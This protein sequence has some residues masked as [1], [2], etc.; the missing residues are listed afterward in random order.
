MAKQSGLHQIRGKVGEH[1]YYKQTGVDTGLIRSINQGMSNRV[2][3]GAEYANT[4][5]NNVEFGHA[6]QIAGTLGHMIMPKYRPMVLPFSQSK[7][8]R[9]I[10]ERIKETSGVW[11]QRTIPAGDAG[12]A[13]LV[14][15]LNS[16]S[17]VN[18]SDYGLTIATAVDSITVNGSAEFDQFMAAIGCDGVKVRAI[19]NNVQVGNYVSSFGRYQ[20]TYRVYNSADDGLDIGDSTISFLDLSAPQLPPV[21]AGQAEDFLV[22]VIVIMPYRTVGSDEH[23]LQEY[24]TFIAL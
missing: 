21:P 20:Y 15:A 17:K 18:F 8:A 24:C 11:G 10:L 13:T 5:L 7:M 23:I 2:K 6:C 12:T 19:R 22:D 1:S 4:R 9:L 14:A 3:T 16:V